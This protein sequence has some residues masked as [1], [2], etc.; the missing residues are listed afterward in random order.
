VADTGAAQA[1]D[2]REEGREEVTAHKA[3]AQFIEGF[4]EAL[5]IPRLLGAECVVVDRSESSFL[6]VRVGER[7]VERLVS[8]TEQHAFRDPAA[9]G[10]QI[11]VAMVARMKDEKK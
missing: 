1:C 2:A 5:L 4:E 9:S 11:G 3:N 6:Q 8:F 10:R 7:S